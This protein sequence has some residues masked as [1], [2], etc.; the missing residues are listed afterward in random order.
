MDTHIVPE[1]TTEIRLYDYVEDVFPVL[2]SRSAVKKAITRGKILVNGE[3]SKT[4]TWL[5]PHD[6]IEML[7]LGGTAPKPYNIDIEVVFEDEFMMV[8]NKP[9]GIPVSGNQ[10]KT[11]QNAIINNH[12]PSNQEDALEWPKPVHRLDGATSGLLIIAKTAK[13][14]MLLGQKFENKEIDKKYC[15][16][17][18]GEIPEEGTIDFPID[19][20]DSV[21]DYKRVEVV[22]SLRSGFLCLVDL[23]PQ[24]GRTHQIRKHLAKLGNPIMGDALYGEEGKIFKGKGLFLCAI[25]LRL[26]HPITGEE[27]VLQIEEPN[28]YNILLQREERRFKQFKEKND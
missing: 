8:I 10:F 21:T 28:K 7:D 2:P 12:V 16:I 26:N 19:G 9:G 15:A 3:K 11:I 5:K 20:H 4:G 18:M 17:V 1:G 27:M 22:P 13:A 6:K 23:Y 24:T 25:G 14:L